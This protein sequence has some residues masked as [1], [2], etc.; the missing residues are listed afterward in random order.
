MTNQSIF[1]LTP[2]L[3]SM[4]CGVTP[5]EGAWEYTGEETYENNTCGE[6][7]EYE[8]DYDSGDAAFQL[9]L[10]DEGFNAV[11]L[12][13]GE[14]TKCTSNGSNFEC[15]MGMYANQVIDWNTDA[16]EGEVD[17]VTTSKLA[18]TASF[19]DSNSGELITEVSNSCTGTE[20]D[21]LEESGMYV[22]CDVTVKSK[23]QHAD[24]T[25]N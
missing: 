18:M 1:T 5:T 23:I 25:K 9:A 7:A 13:Y 3:F 19:G 17:A 22:F 2:L 10:T 14:T 6:V 20:C 11:D 8:F 16:M 24:A 15:D 12:I 21:A 4:A